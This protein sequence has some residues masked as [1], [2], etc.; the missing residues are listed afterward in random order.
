MNC[1]K[2]PKILALLFVALL[3]GCAG[4]PSGTIDPHGYHASGQASWYGRAHH[5]KRTASG[6]RFDQ[7]S[8]TAAHR[9]LPFGTLLRVTNLS[10]DRS[11]IVR[12]NDRGPY[13]RG[14]IIDLSRQAAETLDMIRAGTAKVRVEVVER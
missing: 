4:K 1:L 14:R 5:G 8:L 10:N 6:E 7:H 13:G 2:M 12:V 11:V 3:A 9:T